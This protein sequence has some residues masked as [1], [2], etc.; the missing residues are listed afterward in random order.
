[1]VERAPWGNGIGLK[2]KNILF[3]VA[4]GIAA[5]KAADYCRK[6]TKFGAKVHPVLTRNAERFITTLT[7]SALAGQRAIG[8]HHAFDPRQPY[9]HI[10]LPRRADCFVICP[11]T[12]NTLA[13][14]ANGI[15]DDLL[16]TMIM[17]HTGK[18][19]FF[20]AMNPAM[21]SNP[22]T[23]KNIAR[24]K[25]AGHVVVGPGGGTVA[26]GDKGRGRLVAFEEFIHAIQCHLLPKSLAGKKVLITCGPTRE[27]I[28]P[29]RFISNRSSGK[30]G[31]EL[32]WAA[33][34]IGAECYLVAGP[35][36]FG[37]PPGVKRFMKIEKAQEMF[38]SV[39]AF[40]RDMDIIIMAAAVA[41][42]SP[43]STESEKIKKG[44]DFLDL[45]LEKTPDI[46]E[47]LSKNRLEGQ[48]LIGFSAETSD[49]VENA[50]QKMAKKP[51]D[52]L[53]AND[54][55]ERGA[56][57][58]VDTNKVVLITDGGRTVEPLP[59]MHKAEVAME[60]LTRAAEVLN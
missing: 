16:T 44:S 45:H 50:R 2:G 31:F 27:P 53:V 24:L 58:D 35:T 60:I 23:Q 57:F 56:G 40:Y 41:D 38:E 34:V 20:P 15:A 13:K 25:D 37:P 7:F 22:I 39:R 42:Y 9:S 14:A 59:L 52:I 32:A 6:L 47:F 19:I 18:I 51:V 28:D 17:A 21:F 48:C 10:E 8:D 11:A 26:C 29:V 49:L 4:G 43:V 33:T 46:L 12:C 30:M 55:T 36:P 54:V 1:M 3:G 5:Y